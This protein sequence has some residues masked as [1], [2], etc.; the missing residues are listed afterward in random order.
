M[1]MMKLKGVRWAGLVVRMDK[2]YIVLV[3]SSLNVMVHGGAR[4]GK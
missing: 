2:K 3:E 4:E 1:T